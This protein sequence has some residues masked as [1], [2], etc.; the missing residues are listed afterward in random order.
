MKENT[1][2][3]NNSTKNVNQP[4][5]NIEIPP[6]TESNFPLHYLCPKCLKFPLINF[7]KDKK[8][9]KLTCLCYNNKKVLIK[10]YLDNISINSNSISTTFLSST[11]I[12]LDD[13]K[14]IICKKHNKKYEYFCSDCLCHYCNKEECIPYH[15][16]IDLEE[17]RFEDEKIN[18]LKNKVN[19]DN[20]NNEEIPNEIES[21]NN[22]MLDSKFDLLIE[23]EEK[24]FSKL[25]NIIINDYYNFPNILHFFNIENLFHFYN[26]KDNIKDEPKINEK[27]S[28]IFDY[29]ISFL[30]YLEKAMFKI[31]KDE[32]IIEYKNN[33]SCK[34]KLIVFL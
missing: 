13:N 33:I 26:I 29:G 22:I 20:I 10:D 15:Y 19:L 28:I 32:I 21:S 27:K 6:K 11:N 25:I 2:E 7:C 3:Q 17:I 18:E 23:E 16:L 1:S 14:E 12:N 9:I 5:F 8:Y 4:P 34:T 30:K 24:S 31:Q